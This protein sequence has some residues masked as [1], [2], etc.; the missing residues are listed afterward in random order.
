MEELTGDDLLPNDDVRA[1][2][3]EVLSEDCSLRNDPDS[4]LYITF[5]DCYNKP[6]YKRNDRTLPKLWRDVD[7]YC[8]DNSDNDVPRFETRC[9]CALFTTSRM[10]CVKV[11]AV[12]LVINLYSPL[13]V[14][15]REAMGARKCRSTSFFKVT[16]HAFRRVICRMFT[17]RGGH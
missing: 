2:Y 4:R 3:S 13:I 14:Y 7:I 16:G 5:R 6:Q 11:N 9:V 1:E 10:P 8:C 15:V 12:L 17:I